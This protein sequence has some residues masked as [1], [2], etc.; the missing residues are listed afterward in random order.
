MS[1]E[2]LSRPD[3][4]WAVP[5]AWQSKTEPF[6]GRSGK[7][8]ALD[9]AAAQA[10]L[11]QLTDSPTQ[12]G[13]ALLH[14]GSHPSLVQRGAEYLGAPAASTDPIGAAVCLAIGSYRR[15]PSSVHAWEHRG[16]LGESE[17]LAD[18]LVHTHGLAFAVA[19][20]A[21]LTGIRSDFQEVVASSQDWRK[22]PVNFLVKPSRKAKP[23]TGL[24]RRLRA[25]LAAADD[26]EYAGAVAATARLRARATLPIRLLTSYLLP[27]EQHWVTADLLDDQIR[28]GQRGPLWL[29]ASVTEEAQAH[30]VLDLLDH[31]NWR[32]LGDR[33]QL[34]YSLAAHL[35]PAAARPLERIWNGRYGQTNGPA[36]NT[37]ARIM[38]HLPADHAFHVLMQHSYMQGTASALFAAADRFPARAL[39]VFAADAAGRP[40]EFRA[41]VLRHPE[42]ATELAGTLPEAAQQ[43][44]AALLARD[45]S[46][47]AAAEADIPAILRD[48]PWDRPR[49]K[50]I[51]VTGLQVPTGVAVAWRPEERERALADRTPIEPAQLRKQLDVIA[52][53]PAIYSAQLGTLAWAEPAEAERLLRVCRMEW[54]WD[55]RDLFALIAA[56][57]AATHDL[58]VDLLSKDP[59][60]NAVAIAPF[61]SA[62]VAALV[63]GWLSLVSRRKIAIDWLRRHPA[64]AARAFIP[65]A[66]GKGRKLR[67]TH[68][69]ALRALALLGHSDEIHTAA[70]EY[71]AEAAVRDVLGTDPA[72]VVPARIPEHPRWLS[73]AA[74]PSIQLEAGGALPDQA[75][76]NLLTL[77]MLS[78]PGA[79]HAG[80]IPVRAACTADSLA[81]FAGAVHDEWKA[82]GGP[83]RD[84]WV[85]DMLGFFGND[86]TIK[87]LVSRVWANEARDRAL[88]TLV[89]LGSHAALLALRDLSEKADKSAVRDSARSRITDV[90][91]VLGLT[92]DQL[93]D[94]LVPDLGLRADGTALLDFG[95]RQ[96]T[97]DFDEQLRTVLIRGDGTV[98]KALPKPGKNDDRPLATAAIATYRQLRK[99]VKRFAAD[100]IRRLER[101]MVT[102]RRF[103]VEELRDEYLGHPLRRHLTRRLIW[104]EFRDDRLVTSFRIA[105]DDSFADAADNALTLAEDAVLGIAHPVHLGPDLIAAWSEVL[106]DYELLQPFSQI[107][108]EVHVLDA[109]LL[110][111]PRLAQAIGIEIPIGRLFGLAGRGWTPM[112]RGGGPSN[113]FDKPLPGN[114]QFSIS[115]D[116][117]FEL[118]ETPPPVH[119]LSWNYL[120][121]PRGAGGAPTFR[122]LGPLT[123]S[124]I[125][126][127]LAWLGGPR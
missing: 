70:A 53:N 107:D 91:E 10:V 75:V 106:T 6:R 52:A 105:E 24:M 32:V 123:T 90:A 72:D 63:S 57:G 47:S 17:D 40:R 18:Y 92:P 109:A 110:D 9:H 58:V 38:S 87:L 80:L 34:V 37:L 115:V 28:A 14:P 19:A 124:E 95:P 121:G 101:A 16:V 65:G 51:A 3:Q 71:K 79:P 104:A 13:A 20:T 39:R 97:V 82:A 48:P 2:T 35:G 15:V 85:W 93:A 77:V 84:G 127:D 45:R 56:H 43:V 62:E 103:S 23:P 94:R 1:V 98:V 96:F 29:L 86:T 81:A 44:I 76:T 113:S 46:N 64:Y 69:A 119:T 108:R 8:A 22:N 36:E 5:A 33:P 55:Q 67:R 114:R 30:R 12:V 100:Q 116:P 89:A 66:V 120:S 125:L 99:D 83:R 59:R 122:A 21:G 50:E 60:E 26:A 7:P 54:C 41:H 11:A 4:E 78:D 31:T 61:E 49:G 88:D 73:V 27:T 74:L 117:G 68:G 111:E 42:L 118:F 102:E 25:L 112:E 126:R